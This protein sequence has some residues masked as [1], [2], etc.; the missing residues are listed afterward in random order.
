MFGVSYFFLYFVYLFVSGGLVFVFGVYFNLYSY[1]LFIDYEF[2][3][4][5]SLIVGVSFYFDY[6]SLLFM[7]SVL[8]ISSMVILY[9][10]VYMGNDVFSLR[11]LY[12]VVLFVMSMLMLIVSPNLFSILLGWD[13]LG[14]ISYCLVVYFNNF[15]SYN[16]GMLTVL[17]NRIG[18]V[19]I[20][21]SLA[22]ILNSGTYHFSYIYG[23]VIYSL[24]IVYLLVLAAFTKSAQVPFS[25]WLP[26][27]MAAPTPVSALVHSSTLVTAG[28][29][30]LIRF[31][32]ILFKADVSLFLGL[33]CLTMILAGV[34][35]IFE[36]DL[37]SIIALSTL[38]Q[39][40][41]MM[42]VLFMGDSLISFFHLLNH[43][44]FKS[45]LF[46]CAGLIIHCI[47]DSQ[48]IRYLNYSIGYLPVTIS[49]FSISS[50]SLC[51]IP[52]M[53]GF[54]SKHGIMNFLFSSNA[55]YILMMVFCISMITTII[56]SFRL[57][58][59]CL[60]GCI[61]SFKL[62]CYF[63]DSI[64]MVSMLFLCFMSIAGGSVL[65]WILLIDFSVCSL[66]D[67]SLLT[68]FLF[69]TSF[70]FGYCLSLMNYSFEFNS[71][72]LHYFFGSMWFL[73]SFSMHI[74]YY[75][76][77][78]VSS[79]SN[80]Y[81][82]IG[83]SEASTLGKVVYFLSISSLIEKYMYIIGINTMFMLFLLVFFLIIL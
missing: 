60:Q 25:S 33:S 70:V 2:F 82:G 18:D 52:Y 29:Y 81:Y 20:L 13:G 26:A 31:D 83:W 24:I 55:D 51:G 36:F 11:F 5:N 14:L 50:L 9:S 75:S 80:S 66:F 34:G 78:G 47:G 39:L 45:L 4:L 8:M 10:H 54:Y 65:Y 58:Y 62:N 74:L 19:A 22:Y 12:L 38:S 49:C 67:F 69:L 64:M 53:T 76:L 44:F 59:Y 27:A 48:D 40:G 68:L 41:L 32:F 71:G 37:K 30:M 16:A 6:I 17:T 43:A 63:E 28:V 46:L 61:G 73:P 7:G 77:V 15:K 79:N 57:L 42:M 23:D 72:V 1:S 21:I 56:Y 3:S 35:A